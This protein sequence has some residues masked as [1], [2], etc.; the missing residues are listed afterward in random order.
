MSDPAEAISSA[1]HRDPGVAVLVYPDLWTRGWVESEAHSLAGRAVTVVASVDE[2]LRAPPDDLVLLIP[3]DEV[4][5]VYALD[6]S[7]DRVLGL[8][9]TAPIVLFLLREGPGWRA[10]YS[11][12]PSLASWVS[13][14]DPDPDALAQI[15]VEAERA[16]FVAA[17][18]QEPEAWLA[19]WD[20][21]A[22]ERDGDGIARL[23]DALLLVG[24]R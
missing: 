11:D 16:R 7:R 8:A 14:S 3:P 10:L 23:H 5:A 12:C 18:G 4:A 6:G 2:A 19:A 24:S 13:G 15:D 17:T 20:A 9:R 1:L 22:V 21:G